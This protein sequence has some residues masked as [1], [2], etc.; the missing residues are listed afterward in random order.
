MRDYRTGMGGL[1]AVLAMV[2]SSAPA[3]G[4]APSDA[5]WGRLTGWRVLLGHQSV[6]ANL[7]AGLERL[8]AAREGVRIAEVA[9]GTR[10]APGTFAHARLGVNG[11]PRS[12]L[13]AFER[14]I[15]SLD[16]PPDVA[17]V[18]LCYADVGAATDVEALFDLYR[19]TLDALARR[20]PGTRFVHVTI[21]L[22]TVEGG[23]RG[24]LMRALG[25]APAGALE[26][27]RREAYNARLREAYGGAALFDLARLES[28]A[29]DGSTITAVWGGTRTRALDPA[30]TLDGGHLL[31]PAQDRLARALVETL[32]AL[33]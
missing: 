18:K 4:N 28:T 6:G 11:D 31:P 17:A 20:H 30:A 22:T 16:P 15:A 2:L 8:A 3:A 26:N 32:G 14:L 13:A 27:A 33:P 7:V 21:P 5:A 1:A 9:H 25:R 23:V 19:T 29:G 12:K 10:L 24:L